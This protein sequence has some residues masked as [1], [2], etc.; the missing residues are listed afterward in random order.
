MLLLSGSGIIRTRML[1]LLGLGI[2]RTGML[3]LL[4]S[5]I[6]RTGMLTRGRASR[7][8]GGSVEQHSRSPPPGTEARQQRSCL[9]PVPQP[10]RGGGPQAPR[11]PHAWIRPPLPSPGSRG[12][13][14]PQGAR[15]CGW[16]GCGAPVQGLPRLRSIHP[17]TVVLPQPG[18]T[19]EHEKRCVFYLKVSRAEQPALGTSILLGWRTAVG[20]AEFWEGSELPPRTPPPH[21]V[22]EQQ[23]KMSCQELGRTL[24]SL[25][26]NPGVLLSPAG[27]AEVRGG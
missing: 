27:A 6:I 22:T 2:I 9:P 11:H 20:C 7:A 25:C 23:L 17:Q 14:S 26:N 16:M 21:P 24:R 5:G 18:C 19:S 3:L 15:S 10:S 1:L 8:E 13:C 4:G 12:S